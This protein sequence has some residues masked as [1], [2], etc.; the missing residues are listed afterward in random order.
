ML[1]ALLKA[2]S[3]EVLLSSV[4]EGLFLLYDILILI[5]LQL[6]QL[7]QDFFYK[8]TTLDPTIYQNILNTSVYLLF[9]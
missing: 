1:E 3:T 6:L 7:N 5:L 4:V 9:F 2:L 8:L